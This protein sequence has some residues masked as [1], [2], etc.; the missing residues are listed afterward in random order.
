[1][2]ALITGGFSS[3]A[4]SYPLKEWGGTY[5]ILKVI[6]AGPWILSSEKG[7]NFPICGFA[8][9][10]SLKLLG[11]ACGMVTVKYDICC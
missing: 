3:Q 2:K 1:M 8:Q 5:F 11:E 7:K 6:L 10:M 9:R 4:E